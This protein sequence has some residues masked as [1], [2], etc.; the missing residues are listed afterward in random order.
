MKRLVP[1][2]GGILAV[3]DGDMDHFPP[4]STCPFCAAHAGRLLAN[5]A[6]SFAGAGRV[7]S[8]A[9]VFACVE[10]ETWLIA[11]VESLAGQL[12]KD[13]R[14][15]LPK[16]LQFPLGEPESHGKK[17]V[18]K[19]WPSY[20]PPLDQGPLT[21][22]LCLQTVRSKRLPSFTRLEHALDQLLAACASGTHVCTPA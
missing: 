19:H 21:E 6:A 22:I 2:T 16:G 20:T 14:S 17:W 12:L 11:G 5:A 8:L 13:G 15:A 10:Y 7:F 3:Y 1:N 9:V 4:G 18:E